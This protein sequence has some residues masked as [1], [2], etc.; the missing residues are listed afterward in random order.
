MFLGLLQEMLKI[1]LVC[2][3]Y[4]CMNLT[5]INISGFDTRNV[6]DFSYMF[7]RCKSLI[8]LDIRNFDTSNI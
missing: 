3:F 6:E 7:Y 4:N 5:E 8:K 1:W 2:M